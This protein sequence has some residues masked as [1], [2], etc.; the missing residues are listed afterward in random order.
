[1][2][3]E[4]L[5]QGAGPERRRRIWNK[6]R[7][8]VAAMGTLAA[9]AGIALAVIGLINFDHQQVIAGV[10]IIIVSTAIYVSILVR[11][12]DRPD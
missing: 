5:K 3:F 7:I 4:E 9:A 8:F 6:V 2:N 1:M 11:D 10:A 12:R